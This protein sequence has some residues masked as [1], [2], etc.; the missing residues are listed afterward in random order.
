MN[1]CRVVSEH[2]HSLVQVAA[3]VGDAVAELNDPAAED[4]ALGALEESLDVFA[5]WRHGTRLRGSPRDL[6]R[7]ESV[8]G[9]FDVAGLV[10][11]QS[12]STSTLYIYMNIY[13]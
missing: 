13:A 1:A 9:V 10:G 5:H 12:L 11:G 4:A 2:R 3:A 6:A 7:P 8:F